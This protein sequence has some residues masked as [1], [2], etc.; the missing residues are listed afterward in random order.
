MRTRLFSDRR[1]VRH[2]RPE[3]I[4]GP[5]GDEAGGDLLAG[6]DSVRLSLTVREGGQRR[7]EGGVED[8]A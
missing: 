8:G 2:R 6:G 3:A 1:R 7:G 4:L 5:L